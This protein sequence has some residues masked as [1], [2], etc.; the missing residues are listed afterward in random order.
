MVPVRILVTTPGGTGHVHPMVPLAQ[1]LMARGHSVLWALPGRAVAQVE[2]SG[3]RTVSASDLPPVLPADVMQLYPELRQAV[4][5]DVPD[6]MFGKLFGAIQAPAMLPG[7][8]RVAREWQPDLL[9]CDAAELAGPVVA[10]ELGVPNVT[11]GFGP[12]LPEKRY[13]A[14]AEDVAPLWRS[15]GLEPRPYAGCFDH[16]Y[17]DPYPPSLQPQTA[18][19]VDRR[20]LLRPVSYAGPVHADAA[21]PLPTAREGRPLIYFTM[22]TVFNTADLF[23][24]VIAGLAQLDAG[25]LVTLGPTGDPATLGDQPAHVQVER[26]VPQTVLLPHCNVVVSHGGSG[27]AISAIGHGLP[28]LC[29]PQGAD[30]FINAAAISGVGAGLSLGAD[31]LSVD[32]VRQS[33]ERLLSEETFRTAAQRVRSSLESM[34]GPDEVSAVL[35]SL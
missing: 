34:P 35:E 14:A 10:A 3:V 24:D 8:L 12:L 22:G 32:A 13:A 27:T 33:V 31:E 23:R 16:L 2:Q 30:Q 28:Q 15:R 6:R 20:Q 5:V 7:L 17:V 25:L 1:A 9:L 11:K 18:P 21:L 29:L 19:H 4:P 26:Y